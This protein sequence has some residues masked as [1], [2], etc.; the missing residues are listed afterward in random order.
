[1]KMSASLTITLFT[2]DEKIDTEFSA[3]IVSSPASCTV[4]P[5]AESVGAG[6][7]EGNNDAEDGGDRE[8]AVKFSRKN[9]A[10]CSRRQRHRGKDSGGTFVEEEMEGASAK[11]SSR[12]C[13]TCETDAIPGI[14]GEEGAGQR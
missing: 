12:R 9:C 1:M 3:K 8:G 6:E 7:D 2:A 5:F 13:T 11:N 10:V 14:G 4:V